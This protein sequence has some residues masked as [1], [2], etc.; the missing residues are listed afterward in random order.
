MK[1]ETKSIRRVEIIAPEGWHIVRVGRSIKG[2]MRNGGA[3]TQWM[4][5]PENIGC[6]NCATV[7][8][9]NKSGS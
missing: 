3:S 4:K 6:G 5:C 7:I 9:K 2:D 1:V 8:R